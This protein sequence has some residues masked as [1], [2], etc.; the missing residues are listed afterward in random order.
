LTIALPSVA[1]VGMVFL[2]P[3]QNPEISSEFD[4]T[5]IFDGNINYANEAGGDDTAE[6]QLE[7]HFLRMFT[8]LK[9]WLLFIAFLIGS[10][11]G[12]VV[13]NNIGKQTIAVGGH[14]GDQ[15]WLVTVLSLSNCTGRIVAGILVDLLHPHV[16]PVVL[17]ASSILFMGVSVTYLA[18]VAQVVWLYPGVVC[19][20]LAYGAIFSITPTLVNR[21]FGQANF[22]GNC[23]VTMIAPG[24]CGHTLILPTLVVVLGLMP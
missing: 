7:V 22:G 2:S 10:G 4:I 23:N 17:L 15:D 20:G 14:D 21:F 11:A 3:M 5:S 16:T 19:V 6:P 8:Y 24:M 1:L 12:L 18:F 9:Y 13:I